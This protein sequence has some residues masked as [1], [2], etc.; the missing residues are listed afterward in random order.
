MHALPG[1]F[2]KAR[3]DWNTDGD[4]AASETTTCYDAT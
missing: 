4:A 2:A 1:S 3:S